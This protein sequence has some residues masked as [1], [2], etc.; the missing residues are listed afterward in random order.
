MQA[1]DETEQGISKTNFYFG[2]MH[3][4]E[5]WAN[6]ARKY[7]HDGDTSGSLLMIL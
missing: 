4:L 7:K 3:P 1:D 6:G 2:D 5:L